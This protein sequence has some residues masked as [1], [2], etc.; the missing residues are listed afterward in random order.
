[1]LLKPADDKSEQL[2]LLESLSK[3]SNISNV[4]RD[5]IYNELSMLRAGIKGEQDSAYEIDF[6][7]GKSENWMVIHDLRL[8]CDGR[9]AQIDHLLISRFLECY[10][11]ETKNYSASIEISEKGEFTRADDV[12][13]F[14]IASPI[15]QN[16][17]H[18]EVLRSVFEKLADKL[19]KRLGIKLMP[20]FRNVVLFSKT[21]QIKRPI[22]FDTRAVMKA[23]QF[24]SWI[25]EESNSLK[26]SVRD[27]IQVARVVSPETITD[28]GIRLVARHKPMIPNYHAKF[29]LP[30]ADLLEDSQKVDV[31]ES[32]DKQIRRASA[33]GARDNWCF[34]CNE[35]IGRD[36]AQYCWD[37]KPRFG[38]RAYCRNCQKAH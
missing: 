23:E 35:K 8:E 36:V 32:A 6:Y 18:I 13:S 5:R 9:V 37:H 3:A 27:F 16:N 21:A 25:E 7:F 30:E 11:I 14:G 15:E 24:K 38:G 17:K 33:K 12:R 34:S 22:K 26:P 1:M 31:A 10:V 19:P 4:S 29:G 20:E 2:N 28:L